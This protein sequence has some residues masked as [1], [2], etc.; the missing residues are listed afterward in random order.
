MVLSA[1]LEMKAS[2]NLKILLITVVSQTLCLDYHLWRK[3]FRFGLSKQGYACRRRWSTQPRI[4]RK[5]Q[6]PFLC[7][8]KVAFKNSLKR[9]WAKDGERIDMVEF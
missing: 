1:T 7:F 8:V 5:N 2:F 6:K 4:Q 9:D 3:M